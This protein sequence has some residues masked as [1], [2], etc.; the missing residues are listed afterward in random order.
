MRHRF[1]GILLG[2]AAALLVWAAARRA[3]GPGPSGVILSHCDGSLRV[4]AV[5]YV[6][7][8]K[9]PAS[10]LTQFLPHLPQTVQVM[11]AC[12]EPA[13]FEELQGILATGTRGPNQCDF[14]AIPLRCRL[15]PVYTHHDE[16]AW[17]RDRWIALKNRD[18]TMTL[19]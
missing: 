7:G 11:V 4:I 10:V 8:A 5:Q 3:G 16:T 12:P 15:V 14:E 17:S 18:S 6:S 1:F 2:F 19:L 13:D 9:G